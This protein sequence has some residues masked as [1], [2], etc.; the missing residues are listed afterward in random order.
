MPDKKT[1]DYR[2]MTKLVFDAEKAIRKLQDGAIKP[3]IEALSADL[4]AGKCTRNTARMAEA[5]YHL[6][7]SQKRQTETMSGF[8]ATLHVLS[9]LA[10]ASYADWLIGQEDDEGGSGLSSLGGLGDLPAN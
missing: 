3:L 9:G 7:T 4:S 6:T 10:S 2:S 5:L 1:S 8:A